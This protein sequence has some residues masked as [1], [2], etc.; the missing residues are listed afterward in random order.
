MKGDA[1]YWFLAGELNEWVWG[2][3]VA[4]EE[5]LPKEYPVVFIS[6]HAGALG[7]IAVMSSLPVRV[8]PWVISDMMEWDKAAEYLRKDFVEPQLHIPPPSSGIVSGLLSQLSVRLLHAV[9]CIP[10][11]RGEKIHETYRI[12]I[13]YLVEGRS[14]LIFPEDPSR[15]MNETYKMTPFYKGFTRLGE[16]YYQRTNRPL[17]F[18]PLA[19][20]PEAREIKIGKPVSYNPNNDPVKERIRIKRVLES[21]IRNLYLDIAGE[22]YAGIPLPH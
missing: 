1:L 3:E 17:R 19:V 6:N 12:S 18:Y 15:P 7:P 9:E 14:L 10:V 13:E 22:H 8:Y 20:H 2:G 4:N 11:W 21:T 5:S 16:M